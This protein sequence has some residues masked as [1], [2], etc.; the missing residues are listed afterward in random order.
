[1]TERPI[2]FSGPMVNS[3][4]AGRKTQTRR[5]VR[6]QPQFDPPKVQE[7]WSGLYE[8]GMTMWVRETCWINQ[9]DQTVAYRADDEMPEHMQGTRWIPSIHM[10]RWASRLSL[11]V[12]EVR[13]QQVQEISRND[14]F[15]EGLPIGLVE[16]DGIEPYE[17]ERCLKTQFRA[18][19]DSAIDYPYW[20]NKNP[21]VW[22]ITFKVLP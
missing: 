19:W 20:W 1:M 22:A 21:W 2:I 5:V 3:I 12:T 8:A 7:I 13:V 17:Y 15:A 6:P 4:L 9:A 16:S 10:P 11:E 18:V 14:C